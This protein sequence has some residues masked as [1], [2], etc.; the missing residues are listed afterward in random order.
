[1]LIMTTA[2]QRQSWNKSLRGNLVKA[3]ARMLDNHAMRAV[4]KAWARKRAT[5]E[6]LKSLGMK[7]DRTIEELVK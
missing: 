4:E 7:P 2:Q 6:V 3:R 5:E 1:M